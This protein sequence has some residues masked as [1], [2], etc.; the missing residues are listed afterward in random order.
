[1]KMA[2]LSFYLFFILDFLFINQ[3]EK[4][5]LGNTGQNLVPRQLQ[6]SGHGY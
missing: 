2:G 5:P 6:I 4:C 1:M 3:L